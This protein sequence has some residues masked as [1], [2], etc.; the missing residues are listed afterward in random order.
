MQDPP[1]AFGDLEE[2]LGYAVEGGYRVY[3]AD[4]RA[5]LAWAHR[6]AGDADAARAE[7]ARARQMSEE[8]GYGWGRGEV[9]REA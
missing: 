2:A 6:A 3:E 9:K 8:M 4:V 7:A 1:A 5:A